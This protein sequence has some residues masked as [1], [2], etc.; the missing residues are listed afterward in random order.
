MLYEHINDT[1]VKHVDEKQKLQESLKQN[2]F[3]KMKFYQ[4]CGFN[5][6]VHGVG[7]KREILNAYLNEKLYLDGHDVTVVNG[8]HSSTS[9]KDVLA[10]CLAFLELTE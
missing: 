4:D 1:L 5:I 7:S 2:L 6:M 3:P 9:I 10:S 8:Y